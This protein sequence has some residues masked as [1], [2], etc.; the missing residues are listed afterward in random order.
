MLRKLKTFTLRVIAGANIASILLL[1]LVG[2][3]DC[4]NPA[5]YP[6]LAN[7]GL[8]FPVILIVNIGFLVFWLIFKPKWSLIAIAGLL[9]AYSPIRT[10]LPLNISKTAPDDALKVISFNAYNKNKADNFNDI[11]IDYLCQEQADIVCLQEYI[12]KGSD[13]SARVK[14]VYPYTDSLSTLTGG[15]VL[16][17]FSRYPI[18]R[19]EFVPNNYELYGLPADPER[20]KEANTHRSVAFFLAIGGDTVCVINNHLEST[21]LSE[22]QRTEFK[23]IVKGDLERDSARQE[24]RLLIDRLGESSA[25]RAPQAEALAHYL[26]SILAS[27]QSQADGQPAAS[28][29]LGRFPVI[30][31][32]D[33]NDGPISYAHRTIAARLTDCYRESANGPGFSY[34]QYGFFVRIDNIM[35]SDDWTPFECKTDRKIV[36]SDHYPVICK[37]KKQVKP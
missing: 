31:C 29:P 34:N 22:Q 13:D 15:D 3:S 28:G 23:K 24:S 26:D 27:R 36:V 1:L 20:P 5:D 9:L 6:K 25:N 35:C 19:K 18:I 7:I 4:L 12:L 21:K 11:I 8:V 37:L 2:Y 17:I 32:G 14:A 16:S 33:F 30:L 10:Y